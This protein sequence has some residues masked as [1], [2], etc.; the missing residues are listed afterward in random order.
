M[1]L[2]IEIV[3]SFCRIFFGCKNSFFNFNRGYDFINFISFFNI[4]IIIS[5]LI[6]LSS[7]SKCLNILKK[8]FYFLLQTAYTQALQR[9]RHACVSVLI[10]AG[11]KELS[12][13]QINPY[14]ALYC[15][16]SGYTPHA[17]RHDGL[18]A[19]TSVLLKAGIND[20]LL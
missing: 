2:K 13:R 14:H 11:Y 7:Q 6:L 10:S 8:E 16:Y 9:K 20:V 12:I 17:S 19:T 4:N 15:Y 3:L 18:A 1:R 5:H